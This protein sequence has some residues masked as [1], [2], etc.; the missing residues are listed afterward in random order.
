VWL[1]WLLDGLRR[2]R[3]RR[4]HV[5]LRVRLRFDCVQ[6]GRWFDIDIWVRRQ[7]QPVE[8]VRRF[9]VDVRV[10][11]RFDIRVRGRFDIRVRRRLDI[12]IPALGMHDRNLHDRNLHVLWL[13]FRV[14]HRELLRIRRRVG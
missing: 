9:N 3:Q 7:F 5:D 6:R 10:R 11:G 13:R 1:H 12:R 4:L 14:R 2:G 8:R